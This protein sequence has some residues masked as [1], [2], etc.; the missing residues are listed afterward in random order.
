MSILL[1]ILAVYLVGYVIVLKKGLK[2][3]SEGS[4][5]GLG[6][7]L[8]FYPIIGLVWASISAWMYAWE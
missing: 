1:P 6:L 7:V 3:M 2:M 4:K 5:L 8:V